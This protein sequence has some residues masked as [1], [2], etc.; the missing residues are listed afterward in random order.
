M[1]AF[2]GTANPAGRDLVKVTIED[3][4][5][6]SRY[7]GCV[8]KGVKVARAGLAAAPSPRVRRAADQQHRRHHNYVLLEYAQPLLH[9]TSSSSPAP[10]SASGARKKARSCSAWTASSG[11]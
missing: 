9:S 7:I 11:S 3:P 1:P 5:L 2:T 8:I 4:D 6:C 10:R